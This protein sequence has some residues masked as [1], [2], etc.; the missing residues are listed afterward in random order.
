MRA[1][2]SAPTPGR[3]ALRVV[4]RKR[5]VDTIELNTTAIRADSAAPTPGRRALRV[6]RRK[7]PVDT[8][9]L[10][11]TAIRADS[12]AP[13]PGRRALR[14]VRRKRPVDT[15]EL[16]TTVLRRWRAERLDVAAAVRVTGRADPMRSLGPAALRADVQPRRFDLVLRAALVAAGLGGLFLGDGHGTAQSSQRR[17]RPVREATQWSGSGRTETSAAPTELEKSRFRDSD[18]SLSGLTP[19]EAPNRSAQD[20]F[21]RFGADSAPFRDKG[22]GRSGL[23]LLAQ[24]LERGP[25][26]IGLLI[27]VLVG[28]VVQALPALRAEPRAIRAAEDLVRQGQSDRVARP[29]RQIEVVLV[30]VRRAELVVA[31]GV[32]RLVLACRG[33]HLQHPLA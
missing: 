31:P 5:P 23:Q 25:A 30:Q 14:V 13:T 22:R 4:R 18:V 28:I 26:G 8:I 21:A 24:A 12:A 33:R 16:N 29:R 20:G 1:V 19:Q 32:F 7:R 27:L 11:T 6:V 17:K 15:I 3:R 10:N 2:S 9:E